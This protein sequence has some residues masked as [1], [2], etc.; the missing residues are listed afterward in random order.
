M[1]QR[2][3]AWSF[4]PQASSLKVQ[5]LSL[6]ASS[7]K[8]QTSRFCLTLQPSGFRLQVLH[9]SRLKSQ[10]SSFKPQDSSFRLQALGLQPSSCKL[11]ASG[12]KFQAPSISNF[13]ISSPKASSFKLCAFKLYGSSWKL[14]QASNFQLQAASISIILWRGVHLASLYRIPMHLNLEAW[15]LKFEAFASCKLEASSLKL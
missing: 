1:L 12:C 9:A 5:A 15:D 11:Q 4:E 6:K 13:W 8:L 3:I 14:L 10:A 7:L 2:L